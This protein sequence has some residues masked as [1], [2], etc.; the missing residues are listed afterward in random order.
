[1]RCLP[2]VLVLFLIIYGV[3]ATPSSV[4]KSEFLQWMNKYHKTYDG[5]R[6]ELDYRYKVFV[7]NA[8]FVNTFNDK[9]KHTFTVALNKF[10]DL[11]NE[12]NTLLLN[13]LTTQGI[14]VY[15]HDYSRTCFSC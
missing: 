8:K 13:T 9:E 1:M 3:I 4:S 11:T 5:S 7:E 15:V 10:A 2:L 12:V 14:Y 6:S